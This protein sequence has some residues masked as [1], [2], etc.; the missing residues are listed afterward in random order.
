MRQPQN[1]KKSVTYVPGIKCHP[2]ARII[3]GRGLTSVCSGRRGRLATLPRF[4]NYGPVAAER[5]RPDLRIWREQLYEKNRLLI[6][7]SVT[8]LLLAMQSFALEAE[9]KKSTVTPP[10]GSAERKLI[11]DALR[12]KVQ[13]L[14]GLE[15]VF[16]V[17]HLR[18][19]DG[20]AWV[21]ALPQ[22]P[23]GVSRYEDVS[24]LLR[25]SGAAWGVVELP[26]AEEGNDH[27][28]GSPDYFRLLKER[29]PNLPLDIL[30]NEGVAKQAPSHAG[31]SI[32]DY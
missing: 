32:L 2:C 25:K 24:A 30:P 27:C 20:W 9:P 21:H 31:K 6:F 4:V 10:P 8:A 28:L 11:L 14:H 26:C 19:K 15:V 22:S 17:R 12:G 3:P 7:L 16:V 13:Q 23:D 29:F 5:G 1:A 18:V